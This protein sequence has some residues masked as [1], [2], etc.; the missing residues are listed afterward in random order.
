MFVRE[1]RRVILRLRF[2]DSLCISLCM[3]D[4][5]T[6]LIMHVCL[7]FDFDSPPETPG[8]LHPSDAATA[9]AAILAEGEVSH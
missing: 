2:M 9:A 7:S 8:A 5:I 4:L 1:N 6:Y 3:F